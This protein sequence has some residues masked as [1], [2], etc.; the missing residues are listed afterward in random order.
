MIKKMAK[1]L[2]PWFAASQ[3]SL[4]VSYFSS[5]AVGHM[6]A[7]QL[8]GHSIS[9]QLINLPANLIFVLC[10]LG[11]VLSAI[12]QEK[13]KIKAGMAFHISFVASAMG[14]VFLYYAALLLAPNAFLVT[15]ESN[16][17]IMAIGKSQ[18]IS[19]SATML[20]CLLI[21]LPIGQLAL[22]KYSLLATLLVAGGLM[23]T[24][25]LLPILALTLKLGIQMIGI[26]DALLLFIRFILPFAFISIPAY[27]GAFAPQQP[28]SIAVG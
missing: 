14:I 21:F 5:I 2:L 26:S 25:V 28:E 8:A 7:V 16:P 22:R 13:G 11:L 23:L 9:S 1:F 20:I 19:A 10:I 4:G 6:G 15:F 24:A 17:E 18:L 3:L 27:R 12:M